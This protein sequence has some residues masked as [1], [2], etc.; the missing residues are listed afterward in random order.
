MPGLTKTRGMGIQNWLY[1]LLILIL[2]PFLVL[3]GYRYYNQYQDKQEEALQ[4]NLEMARAVAKSFESFIRDVLHQEL[5]IGLAITS[6]TKMTSGDIIR[7]LETS[8]NYPAVRDFTWVNPDGVAIY[9]NNPALVGT[10]FSDRSFVRAVV[11]GR[12]WAVGELVVGK[13]YGKPIFGISRGIRDAKGNLLGV[14]FAAILPDRLDQQLSIERSM[15]GAISIVDRQGMLVYRYPAI[16]TPWGERNWL[17]QYPE[18][19]EVFKGKEIAKTFFATYEGKERLAGIVPI[20][21]IGWAAAAGI[22]KENVTGPIVNSLVRDAVLFLSVSL[23]A[24]LV[25]VALS[26]KITSPIGALRTYASSLGEGEE[27]KKVDVENM[28]ELQDLAKSFNAMAVKVRLRETALQESEE[29]YRR[30]VQNTTAIILRVDLQGI[31]RFANE[32]ALQFFGYSAEE[33]IGKHAV[34]TIIPERESTGRDLAAMVAGIS[35]MPDRYHF[36]ANENI[37]KNGERVWMEWTNSGIYDADGRLKEFLA[38]GIDATERKRAEEAL[39]QSEALLKTLL[40]GSPDPIF[41]KDRES[42]LLLANPATFAIIGKPAEACLGKTDE[43]FYDNPA[44]GRAIMAND[45]RIMESGQTEVFEETV[46]TPSGPRYYLS[47][48]ATHRDSAGNIIGLIGIA[49]DITDR[50]RAEEAIRE[51]QAKLRAAFASIT[52]AIFIAD[53]EGRLIDFNDEFVR[54]HRFRNRDECSRTIAACPTYIDV[55]LSDGTPAPLEQWAMPRALRGETASNVEYHLR[56]RD[57]GEMWWGS[58][59]FAPIKDQDGRITGAIVAGSEI[60]DRKVAEEALRKAKDELEERVKERTYELY[61]E[62]LYSRSLIEASLDPLV[63]ISPEG[64]INDVNRATEEVTG[65]S[66]EKLIGSDFS[67]YFTE[68]DKARAGYEEVFRRGQVRDYPLKLRHRDGRVT[69]VV[70]NASVYGDERGNVMGVFAAAR[71]ITERKRAEQ[72][73]TAERQRLYD[74]LE[75]LPVYAILLTPD[76]RVSF[77]NRFFRERFGEDDGRRCYEYL[78]N[79]TEPCEVCETYTV[80]KTGKPHHWEWKGPDGRNYDIFDFPFI[81][82]DGSSLIM[83]VGVD[84]T[85]RKQAEAALRSLASELVMAEDRERRRVAGILHDEIAQTLAA[86]KMRMD[87]LHGTPYD[88]EPSLRDAKDLLAQS[89]RET[90]ALMN[91]LGNPLLADMG[92]KAACESLAERLMASHPVLIRCVIQDAFK[93]TEP[94]MKTILYQLIRELLTNIVKHSEAGTADVLVNMENGRFLVRVSDDG[95]GFDPQTLGAPTAEG[96]FGLYSIRERLA[97]VHGNLQIESNPGSG[98]VVTAVLPASLVSSP[99]A[100]NARGEIA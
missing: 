74:V 43:Q 29:R 93:N 51:S 39:S 1:L 58:Y 33:L 9:S 10:N 84:V 26:R 65:V 16:D 77:A 73:A 47:T 40:D 19:E 98:T 14:V 27:P 15:G 37:R 100:G 46:S 18:Y 55:W 34:G 8:G 24:F 12:D 82:A 20:S 79:R 68:P 59:S 72:A 70:Y 44:D 23:I 60:T 32:R 57:T 81:D 87:V 67:N 36:N 22:R 80:R 50:K 71:D 17:R 61:A 94:D 89:I 64:K 90:R 30:V 53:A 85:E 62:S 88:Q 25:A 7:L 91:D 41:L 69:P 3:Q 52:Q 2:L 38:V 54:Y 63:T 76:Y 4:A 11:S 42:R 49:R 6:S 78:F 48:K 92:L 75:T 21:S 66:R 86:A 31:I 56:R 45:L 96:G 35:E 13:I 99:S 83:E 28:P 95:V 5:A 97:A